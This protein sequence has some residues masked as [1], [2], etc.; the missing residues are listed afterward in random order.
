MTNKMHLDTF[1]EE[2]MMGAIRGQEM[3]IKRRLKLDLLKAV[4]PKVQPH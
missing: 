4:N 3:W 1:I 2:E